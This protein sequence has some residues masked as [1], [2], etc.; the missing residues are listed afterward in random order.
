MDIVVREIEDL[1]P[2][3]Y[4]PR[5]ISSKQMSDLRDSL[6]RFG[7]VDPVIVNTFEGR[8]GVIIG[9]HQRLKAWSD[10]GNDTVPCVEVCLQPELERELNVRLNK[11]GGEFDRELL[12]Q[13]FEASDLEAWGFESFELDG[14]VSDLD[15]VD[16]GAK[17]STAQYNGAMG[18]P[19]ML[20]M[21]GITG[22]V[23]RELGD[24]CRDHMMELGAEEGQ[25]NVELFARIVDAVLALR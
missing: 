15:F 4:N 8:E 5:R 18:G 25:K 13:F 19:Y 22:S 17:N 2:A 20:N 24:R 7:M 1:T 9:G 6:S 16:G 21:F 12:E 14:M 3:E 10:L 11:N 23:D